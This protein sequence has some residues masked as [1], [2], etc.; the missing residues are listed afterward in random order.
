MQEVQHHLLHLCYSRG[1]PTT[2]IR[3][4]VPLDPEDVA[5]VN[6]FDT[7]KQLHAI[8]ARRGGTEAIGSEAALMHILI[9][10][11]MDALEQ[12]A[13]A[14]RYAEYASEEDDEDRSFKAARLGRRRGGE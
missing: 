4:M 6:S 14:E 8:A 11:G 3:K 12:E 9:L 1:M 7:D 13:E 10:A 2:K 5:R